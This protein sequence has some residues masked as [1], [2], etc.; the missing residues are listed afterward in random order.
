MGAQLRALLQQLLARAQQVAILLLFSIRWLHD[1]HQ[2][3]GVELRQVT[4]IDPI[5][6]NRFAAGRRNTARRHHIAVQAVG[7]QVALQAVADIG[8]FVT[9]PNRK[10]AKV[11]LQLIQLGEQPL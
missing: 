5:G 6:L 11:A 3:I 2:L 9:Q 7:P 10:A 4:G 1:G 8:G